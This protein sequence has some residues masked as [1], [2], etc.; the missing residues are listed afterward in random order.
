MRLSYLAIQRSKQ[1][2]CFRK[3]ICAISEL[4]E[5][6]TCEDT[7]NRTCDLKYSQKHCIPV[8]LRVFIHRIH[9]N[10]FVRNMYFWNVIK[11][12]L[13][14][15]A[16][17]KHSFPA[18]PWYSLFIYTFWC[19]DPFYNV[20]DFHFNSKKSWHCIRPNLTKI[21]FSKKFYYRLEILILSKCY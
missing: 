7:I 4:T 8:E 17:D 12:W 5:R 10:F 18:V 15:I 20:H 21:K 9:L 19:D 16:H 13:I 1:C 14:L 3:L 2:S 11:Q 6:F